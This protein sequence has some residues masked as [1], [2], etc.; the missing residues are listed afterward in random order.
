MKH[1]YFAADIEMGSAAEIT[2]YQEQLLIKRIRG[3]VSRP[4]RVL[5]NPPQCPLRAES[6]RRSKSHSWMMKTERFRR[7]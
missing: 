5:I 7:P 2:S 4:E 3:T 1:P 6:D